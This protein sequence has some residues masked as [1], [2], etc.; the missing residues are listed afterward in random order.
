M[1]YSFKKPLTGLEIDD[2]S[3][4]M[5]QIIKEKKGW[6]L[7]S[8]TEVPLQYETVELSHKDE[9]II[10]PYN[11]KNAM[12][13][14][15]E[16]MSGKISRIGLSLPNESLKITTHSLEDLHGKRTKVKDLIAWKEKATLPFP[17]EKAKITFF[18]FHPKSME[19]KSY[20][21]VAIGFQDIINDFEIN[22]QRLK[23]DA[24]VIRP[25]VIN[26][27]NFY[28]ESLADFGITAFLG[29]FKRYFSFFVFED[30]Q[31]MFYRGKR[32]SDSYFHFIQEIDMTIELF[33][34]EYPD[35]MIETLSLGSQI[36]VT[37]D[38]KS[39]LESYSDID[40]DVINEEDLITLDQSLK[41]DEPLNIGMYTTAIGA[42]QSLIE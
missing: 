13:E 29:L 25:S 30:G 24:E 10:D 19:G 20:Y 15:L 31:M 33:L 8:C 34:R 22:L 7:I 9:N 36:E 21:I 2:L 39:E 35:K 18:P 14:A 5:V 37:T 12:E 38:L 16:N 11:F 3:L 32:R 17:I 1:K 26:H 42:A 4:K 27:I 28:G 23:I 41:N 6:R 40:V